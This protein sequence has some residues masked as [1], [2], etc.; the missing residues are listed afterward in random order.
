MMRMQPAT[1][2]PVSECL[3]GDPDD[4]SKFIDSIVFQWYH[5]NTILSINWLLSKIIYII[6]QLHFS[7][8]EPPRNDDGKYY[9]IGVSILQECAPKMV[10]MSRAAKISVTAFTDNAVLPHKLASS[11]PMPQALGAFFM[12]TR[13]SP[14]AVSVSCAITPTR[15]W[16]TYNSSR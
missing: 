4:F 8:Q 12:H 10:F 9:V 6:L 13:E 7:C 2:I 16:G 1:S 5:L 15:G 3:W 11:L 14:F